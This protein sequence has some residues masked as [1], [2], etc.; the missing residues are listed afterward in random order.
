MT[1]TAAKPAA[2]VRG[3]R[4]PG[5][6][7]KRAQ[8]DRILR[9]DHAGE[10][11]AQRIYAGQLAILGRK[12]CG[13]TI[14]HMQQQE[15]KHLAAF[16]KLI[17]ERRARPTLLHPLWN[18]AGFALG[19]GTALLGEKAA[20]ACTI[21]VEEVIDD[22]YRRQH[23]SL[24]EDE[25]A[26]KQTIEEFRAEEAEHAHIGREHG[27]EE[28]VGYPVMRAAIAAGSRLAIW[29]SERV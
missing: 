15:E 24:G 17:V 13:K 23:E 22:H 9:V 29:L 6:L 27:G 12:P 16:E 20:M 28:T 25:A 21:A 18:V 19:A 4:L 2:A 14:R 5:D 11:G 26:L 1:Q 7:S 10:F 8:I 3:R